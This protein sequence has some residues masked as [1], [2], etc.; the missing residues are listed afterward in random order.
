MF[1]IVGI[2]IMTG[3]STLTGC[4]KNNDTTSVKQTS[5]DETTAWHKRN[6]VVCWDAVSPPDQKL[7]AASR[8]LS[9][10]IPLHYSPDKTGIYF[11]GFGSCK[12]GEKSDLKLVWDK[13]IKM[14]GVS[15]HVG[16]FL[17]VNQKSELPQ[18]ALNPD[19]MTKDMGESPLPFEDLVSEHVLH[20]L[21]HFSGLFHEHA[22]RQA[23]CD[24]GEKTEQSVVHSLDDELAK[25]TY[26]EM[27]TPYDPYSVMNYCKNYVVLSGKSAKSVMI[28]RNAGIEPDKAALGLSDGDRTRLLMLYRQK[29]DNGPVINASHN[30]RMDRFIKPKQPDG[31]NVVPP[32]FI[33][34]PVPFDWSSFPTPWVDPGNGNNYWHRGFSCS[35][36]TR[37]INGVT[38]FVEECTCSDGRKV[39]RRDEC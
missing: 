30:D 37:T 22:H 4:Y 23:N 20:E 17:L 29:P 35:S 32:L 38:N 25:R 18:I 27:G 9:T 39:R 3:L 26:Q 8:H 12:S 5:V 31:S 16:R 15:S 24:L 11:T 36:Y 1:W 28:G 2:L 21:G 13:T 19:L 14:P 33:P 10:T 34:P 6:I 7:E